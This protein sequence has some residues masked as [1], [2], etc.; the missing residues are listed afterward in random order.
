MAAKI[1]FMEILKASGAMPDGIKGDMA[2]AAVRGAGKALAVPF[3]ELVAP[4]LPFIGILGVILVGYVV[5]ALV[6]VLA[7]V[8]VVGGGVAVARLACG[9]QVA[10]PE[11]L[12]LPK[13]LRLRAAEGDGDGGTIE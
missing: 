11:G 9:K 12:P 5:F 4:A 6:Q 7:V 2:E 3:K 1:D 10:L 8:A 13:W